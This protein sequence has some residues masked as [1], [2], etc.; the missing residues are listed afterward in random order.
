MATPRSI[1]R[2]ALQALYQLDARGEAD[3]ETILDSLLDEDFARKDANKAMDLALGA[4]RE[5]AGAD[6]DLRS[7]APEWPP[8]RQPAVD[9]AILRLGHYEMTSG[10]T[11]P[12][13]AVNE[14]V[15]LAKE[16]STDRS[17]AFVNALLDKVL[18]R[19]LA[20]TP[21]LA[22]LEMPAEEPDE[23]GAPGPAL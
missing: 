23:S 2:K 3:V 21:A 8:H 5:R 16:F 18:K 4:W 11:H 9:R 15:R 13:I 19:V 6:A 20:A 7:L 12:K 22:S 14:A 10:R 17:P 1:R